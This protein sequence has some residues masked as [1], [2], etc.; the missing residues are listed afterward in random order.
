MAPGRPGPR[1]GPGGRGR[2]RLHDAM[3]SQTIEI[4]P[5]RRRAPAAAGSSCAA[6]ASARRSSASRDVRLNGARR[7]RDRVRRRADRR[8]HARLRARGP[9]R[10]RARHDIWRATDQ[11][12][13]VKSHVDLG[14]VRA[15]SD[16]A[17]H[18][19][20]LDLAPGDYIV[21]VGAY[22]ADWSAAYDYHWGVHQLR[23]LGAPRSD[24]GS[25][26]A[27]PLDGDRCGDGSRLAHRL[28][29]SRP[30]VGNPSTSVAAGAATPG[31]PGLGLGSPRRRDRSA[32]LCVPHLD[33][34]RPDQA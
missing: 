27:R 21:D 24:D 32:P 6:T 15:R 31:Q 3:R 20:R 11:L 14:A 17:D 25:C 7:G 33:P 10:C 19:D 23:V 5:A 13:L 8:G 34:A 29:G 12:E 28:D 22:H 16:R 26:G 4:T 2:R 9:P 18:V 1:D 30:S